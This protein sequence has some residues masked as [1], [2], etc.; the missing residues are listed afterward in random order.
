[1]RPF[2]ARKEG[3]P[4]YLSALLVGVGLLVMLEPLGYAFISLPFLALGAFALFFFRDP[5]RT[6]AAR[7]DEVVCAA[8]GTVVGLDHL[9]ESPYYPGPTKRVSIFLSVFNVHVNRSPADGVVRRIEYQPGRF[10]NAM[11][12]ASSEHN[13]SNAIWLETGHGP[14]TVRQIAGAIARRIVCRTAEGDSLAKGD[15]IGM[16]KF[17]SRT[18]IYL[19]PNAEILVKRGEKVRA[20]ATVVARF[21]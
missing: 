9:P 4:Y 1:M 11:K 10:T 5:D 21:P 8:D 13:E 18:E 3:A 19:P 12:N 16:I 6:I 17:G 14:I 2:S 15:K 7:P 20:G